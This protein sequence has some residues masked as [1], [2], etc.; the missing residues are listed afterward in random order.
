MKFLIKG[1]LLGDTPQVLLQSF[2]PSHQP[3]ILGEK[4]ATCA[5]YFPECFG[6][7]VAIACFEEDR[8]CF[9]SGHSSAEVCHVIGKPL[10]RPALESF[11]L[12]RL[13]PG[14][15]NEPEVAEMWM[16]CQRGVWQEMLI[17]CR[18]HLSLVELLCQLFEGDFGSTKMLAFGTGDA[19]SEFDHCIKE[20]LI[21]EPGTCLLEAMVELGISMAEISQRAPFLGHQ[22]EQISARV[23]KRLQKIDAEL[24]EATAQLD[25]AKQAFEH[26]SDGLHR[27]QGRLTGLRLRGEDWLRRQ[28][29]AVS[30]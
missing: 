10:P 1:V 5:P 16:L 12:G 19:L 30:S 28:A 7:V 23:A 8:D 24:E 29:E 2:E 6:E 14:W 21:Q 3:L 4:Q 26:V 17:P 22:L 13:K 25:A 9:G 27:E 18:G 20:T 11:W 15:E